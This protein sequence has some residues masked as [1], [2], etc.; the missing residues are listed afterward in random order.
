MACVSLLIVAFLAAA[1]VTSWRVN[2]I[3]LAQVIPG[4]AFV[5]VPTADTVGIQD[6]ARWTRADKT[7]FGVLAVVLARLRR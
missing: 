1:S 3:L 7:A 4:R 2:A 6:E 5:Q